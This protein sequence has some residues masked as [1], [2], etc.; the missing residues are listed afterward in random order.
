MIDGHRAP[1]EFSLRCWAM[2]PNTLFQ[3]TPQRDL[4]YSYLEG[5]KKG[6]ELKHIFSLLCLEQNMVM[7]K[8]H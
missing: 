8:F 7:H 1:G 4:Y 2:L 6:K 5:C 3:W